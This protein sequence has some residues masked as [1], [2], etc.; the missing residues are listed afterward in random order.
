MK[1]DA[2]PGR[3][4]QGWF[5]SDRPGVY[6]GQCSELCGIRHAFM[7]IE[8]HVVTKQEFEAWIASKGG[9]I[10]EAP[11]APAKPS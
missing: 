11:A 5:I 8:L 4:N 2:I 9:K 10:A 3:V 7:P 6:Y 1:Q